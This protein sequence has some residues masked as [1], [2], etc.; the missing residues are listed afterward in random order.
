[1]ARIVRMVFVRMMQ[2]RV[3]MDEVAMTVA[4][5]MDKMGAASRARPGAL[6]RRAL[7]AA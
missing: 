6:A 7:R 2:M 4:L 3:G 1:M 5:D